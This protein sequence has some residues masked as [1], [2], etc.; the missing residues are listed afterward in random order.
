MAVRVAGLNLVPAT[1]AEFVVLSRA[2]AH[3]TRHAGLPEPPVMTAGWLKKTGL[4]WSFAVTL[5]QF[6]IVSLFLM[7]VMFKMD[8][9]VI[10]RRYVLFVRLAP[11]A[12]DRFVFR[13]LLLGADREFFF[14]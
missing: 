7:E 12:R 1:P 13:D 9:F 3:Q 4:F 10:L 14:R 6:C 8:F 2:V 5:V 11:E